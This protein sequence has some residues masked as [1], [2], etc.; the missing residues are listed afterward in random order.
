MLASLY[1]AIDVNKR[2]SSM[3][4]ASALTALLLMAAWAPAAV[5][6]RF[7]YLGEIKLSSAAGKPM[8]SQVIMV[9]K[10]QDR[11]NANIIERAL[12]IYEGGKVQESTMR[13]AVKNHNTFT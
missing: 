6:E 5:P 12:V 11:D 10:I 7:Y 3:R 13:I 1:P 9:E 8:G 2:R 4:A